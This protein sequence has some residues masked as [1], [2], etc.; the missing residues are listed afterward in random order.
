MIVNFFF[1]INLFEF[2]EFW[3]VIGCFVCEV[4]FDWM[5]FI[6]VMVIEICF[7]LL[8][9]LFVEFFI[10]FFFLDFGI[11]LLLLVLK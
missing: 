1:G 9:I 5:V 3:F 2:F 8:L 4:L 10:L 11:F 7:L 6:F